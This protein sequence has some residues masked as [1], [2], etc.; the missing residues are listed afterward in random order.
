MIA[1]FAAVVAGAWRSLAF[2]LL[3]SVLRRLRLVAFRLAQ[4]LHNLTKICAGTLEF[5]FA[6][7]NT[8]L[9]P[10]TPKP[11]SP[12]TPAGKHRLPWVQGLGL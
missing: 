11:P 10:E 12:A 4:L 6:F 8:A 7:R 2:A 3:A 9:K 1:G 5:G